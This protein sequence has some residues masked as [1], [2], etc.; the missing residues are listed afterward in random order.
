M[1]TPYTP[2]NSD[3]VPELTHEPITWTEHMRINKL[4]FC[5]VIVHLVFCP[6]VFTPKLGVWL[7]INLKR[8]KHC[9]ISNKGP[10]IKRRN[11]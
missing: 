10:K 4:H 6:F 7:G 11:L 3:P 1:Q 8:E 5:C 9:G 2:Y